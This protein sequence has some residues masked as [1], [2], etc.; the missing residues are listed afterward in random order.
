V[1]SG[2]RSALRSLPL[3]RRVAYLTT[4]AVA[5]AVA[6]SSVAAYVTI[7]VSLYNALDNEL[8]NTANSLATGPVTADIRALGGLTEASLRAEN[9]S[10]AAVRADGERYF[11]PDERERLVLGD[12]ELAIARTQL[13]NS[14]RSGVSTSGEEYRVVAVPVPGLANYALVLG[15]PLEPTNDILSSLWVVLII[16]GASGVIAAGVVG[17][18]VARSSLRPVR[19]L[20]A[21][22]EHVTVTKELTPIKID[23]TGDIASLAESFN[24]ML[25]SLASSRERQ[26]QLLADAGHELRTPLTSLRTNIDLLAADA[27]SGILKEEDRVAIMGDVTAQLVEF[28]TLIGDLVALARDETSGSPEPLDFRDV[29][30]AALERVR[31]RGH[32][33]QFDVELNPFYVVGDS[34][35]LERAV[36]NLLDNAVKWSPPG[37]I[38]RV[39]LEGNRLRVADQGPG[40]D[41]ADLPHVFDRFY[42]ADAARNTPGTGLGLSIVAK[43]VTQHGGWV[44][45]GRSAQGGAEFTVQLPGSAS[46]ETLLPQPG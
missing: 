43:T 41:D 19:Q 40:I 13:G 22:V 32:G 26:A 39:Q 14:V 10:V 28:T 27:T 6:I 45:A 31:R 7:R 44:R 20:S 35:M 37:G 33:L 29:V 11:V 4:V 18:T 15:R 9:V 30:T 1:S 17:A 25:T 21:A 16:F 34:D 36:T 42:R 8:I 12:R 24:Q 2:L 46:E 3:Q 23:A 38:I 5:L